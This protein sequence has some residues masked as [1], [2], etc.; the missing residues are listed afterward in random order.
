[1]V[2]HSL[3]RRIQLLLQRSDL[4]IQ[5][6]QSSS[7]WGNIRQGG[8]RQAGQAAESDARAGFKRRRR[9]LSWRLPYI[10]GNALLAG[11]RR[12]HA[13]GGGWIGRWGRRRR[14]RN[15]NRRGCHRHF[16]LLR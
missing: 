15:R 9:S 4:A 5:R 8:L 6:R 3:L 1:M 12:G 13:F 11:G 2:A 16:V 10:I 14:R 7:Q